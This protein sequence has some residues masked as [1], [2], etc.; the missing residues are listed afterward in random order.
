MKIVVLGGTGFAG[1]A[2]VREAVR[3]GHEV[4]SVSRS[5]PDVRVDGIQYVLGSVQDELLRHSLFD[6][7]DTVVAALAPRSSMAGKVRPLYETIARE[8]AERQA[9]FI[10]VGGFGS[11][12]PK[13]G[14]PRFSEMAEFPEE[15]RAEATELASVL[16]WL[17]SDGP[18]TLLWTY[19]SP[20]A[21]F[22]AHASIA[23]SGSYRKSDDGALLDENGSSHISD[24]DFA[25]GVLDEIESP[26]QRQGIV[27]LVAS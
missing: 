1:K 3:R 27:S 11:L 25:L 14:A 6:T 2:V 21:E 24:G 23:D 15:Y 22:G 4:I 17:E 26:S 20:A 19:V 16:T 9:R 10:V 13:K 5:E 7:A 18:D 12:R 8:L